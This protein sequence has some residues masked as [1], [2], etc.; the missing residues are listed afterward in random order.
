M[1]TTRTF[2]ERSKLLIEL[3]ETRGSEQEDPP[4]PRHRTQQTEGSAD[5]G[6]EETVTG[7]RLRGNE[8]T[9]RGQMVKGLRDQT[10]LDLK[11]NG[12]NYLLLIRIRKKCKGDFS[13]IYG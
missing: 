11:V 8:M 3:S 7:E 5:D 13:S 12:Y 9:S 6:T 4:L 2:V 1:I 10:G